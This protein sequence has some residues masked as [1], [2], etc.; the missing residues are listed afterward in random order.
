VT[1]NLDEVW[2]MEVLADHGRRCRLGLFLQI[3]RSNEFD[4]GFQRWRQADASSLLGCRN[5]YSRSRET[6][7]FCGRDAKAQ[8]RAYQPF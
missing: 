6:L 3:A 1:I 8:H 5:H 2:D 4:R 7:Q